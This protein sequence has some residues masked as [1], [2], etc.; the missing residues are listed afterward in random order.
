MRAGN[1]EKLIIRNRNGLD[2]KAARRPYFLADEVSY[3]RLWLARHKYEPSM[4][5]LR[6]GSDILCWARSCML[7]VG[8]TLTFLA[9]VCP[10]LFLPSLY[11]IAAKIVCTL[12]WIALKHR[13]KESVL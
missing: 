4:I 1:N 7:R 10:L 6:Y 9:R 12:L 3:V 5:Y 8:A 2:F 11:S 13:E